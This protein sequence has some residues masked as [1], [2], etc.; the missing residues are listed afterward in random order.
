MLRYMIRRL[1][2]GL[3]TMWV[4]MSAVFLVL[5]LSG[6]P[7]LALLPDDA[8]QEQIDAFHRRYGLDQPI[9]VQYGL[10]LAN[11]VRGEFGN[12]LSE[13]TGVVDLVWGRLGATLQLGGVAVVLALAVG[14]PAGVLAAL[15]HNSVWDRLLMMGAFAGQSTPNFFVG[16]VLILVFSLYL[17]LLPSSGDGT[18]RHLILPALTLSTGLM[19]SMARMMRSSLL[20]VI[21]QDYVRTARAKGFGPRQV[22]LRHCLRNAAV[23]VV[24]LFGL[25]FGLLIGGAAITETVFAWPG[26]G[27]FAVK[28]I[29]VRDYPL[30]QYIVLLVAG[31]VVTTN[32]AVDLLYGWL[33]PRVRTQG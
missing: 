32:F 4:V 11:V 10:Y 25:S 23:P 28:A 17:R 24:T 3:L 5:R 27:R 2:R 7:A 13:K 22:I 1:L 8:T 16:I 29:A 9:P 12:S 33:D 14:L 18:W 21:R 30:I 15:R 20:E 31:S 19:A 6:D 26:I